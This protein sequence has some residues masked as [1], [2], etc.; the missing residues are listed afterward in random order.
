MT[1]SPENSA[2]ICSEDSSFFFAMHNLDGKVF[3]KLF[4]C[5]FME[6]TLLGTSS[7]VPTRKRNHAASLFRYKNEMIL[8]DCGEG[9]Q[10][11]FRKAKI[12]PTKITKILITH[13]HGDHILG[14]PGLFM[15]LAANNY[16]KTLEIY[17]PVGTKKNLEKMFGFFVKREVVKWKA[18]EVKE[19]TVFEAMDFKVEALPMEHGTKCLG[20]RIV[21]ND[22]RKI[23]KSKLDKFGV[24]PGRHIKELQSGKDIVYKGKKVKAKDVSTLVKGR[25]LSYV[26]DTRKCDNAVKLAKNSDL[27]ICEST[28]SEDLKDQAKERKHMTAKDAATIAKR[29]KVKKLVLIHF[30]QRYKDESLLEKE[31][32][33]VFK[34]TVA[35]ED[36][37]K[38]VI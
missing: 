36:L 20:Y 17:G 2:I 16:S 21:E 25:V 22:R 13:W 19:G 14:L 8:I 33:K 32:K 4:I 31:A 12:S 28:Y 35:G 15:T 3:K 34:K 30:S 7:M 37:M 1:L 29:A 18:F 23:I 24:K 5:I 10:R 6:I 38:F 26:T 11:Q 27:L 9:T